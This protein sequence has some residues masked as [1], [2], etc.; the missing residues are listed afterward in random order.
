[1]PGRL[2]KGGGESGINV[3][4]FKERKEFLSAV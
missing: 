3:F 2:E 1:M 4:G